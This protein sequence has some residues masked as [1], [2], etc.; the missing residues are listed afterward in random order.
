M[1]KKKN[2]R[3]VLFSM[4]FV[5]LCAC[6]SG[7]DEEILNQNSTPLP[8]NNQATELTCHVNFDSSVLPTLY[9]NGTYTHQ[10][11]MGFG[12]SIGHHSANIDEF[13][14]A[15]STNDGTITNAN[16]PRSHVED[17]Y[18]A[19]PTINGRA[20]KY[21]SGVILED[22]AYNWGTIIF[23]RSKT[24]K[25]EL[26][27]FV[28][29]HNT[30]SNT[31]IVGDAEKY[32]Y[33]PKNVSGDDNGGD[34]N[35]NN[36][37]GDDNGNNNGGNQTRE[38]KSIS[39]TID[40][41]TFKTILVEGGTMDPFYI[42]QTEVVPDKKI[43]FGDVESKYC[44]DINSNGT[45]VVTELHNFLLDLREK[46]GLP[47]RLPTREEWLFAASGGTKSHGY[48]YSGSDNIDDVAW[49]NGNCKKEANIIATKKANELR[50]FDM[51]GNYA[52][53]VLDDS[54][55]NNW[56]SKESSVD[57]EYYGGCW[58]DPATE[59]TVNSYKEGKRS[60]K[61]EGTNKQEKG[62]V[63]AKLISARLVY[64]KYNK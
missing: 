10:I 38:N 51:S 26:E 57:G 43:W 36:N 62:A 59:C 14:I 56:S 29:Y 8:D 17:V 5:S 46:T 40:G 25:I 20:I 48:K 24:R 58:A 32:T 33:E 1:E 34:D 15:I 44:M 31:W 47:W 30:K 50:L 16:T 53:L 39:Y 27:Y 64:N 3:L 13:G 19:S 42:M 52:E 54:S 11:Y 18:V 35:G 23:V 60:G 55:Q 22:K 61:I 7:N 2:L 41:V 45:M 37:G 12:V 4:F 28:R 6:G 63:N 21:F 9:E 49:Y